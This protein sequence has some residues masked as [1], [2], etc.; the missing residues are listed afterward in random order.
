MF[1]ENLFQEVDGTLSHDSASR[2]KCG[3]QGKCGRPR[4]LWPFGDEQAMKPVTGILGQVLA[5]RVE[6]VPSLATRSS[7][8]EEVCIWRFSL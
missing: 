6:C 5:K 8:M 7:N 4:V 1:P 3:Y 2:R